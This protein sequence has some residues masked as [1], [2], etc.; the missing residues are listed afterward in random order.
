MWGWSQ[1]HTVTG[2]THVPRSASS[3]ESVVTIYFHA[4][5]SKDFSFDPKHHRVVIRGGKE[6]GKPE[7]KREVCE[8][9]CSR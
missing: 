9:H 4:I 7:W 2:L 3:S 5:L 8:M 6:F 1:K